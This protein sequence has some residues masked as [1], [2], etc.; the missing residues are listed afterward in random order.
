MSP[1]APHS[2][3]LKP[4][5]QQD[6][7]GIAHNKIILI[8]AR[9]VVTGSFNFTRSAEESNTENLLIIEDKPK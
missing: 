6:V 1:E 9:V 4:G 5:G 8:D 3:G 2:S 7:A